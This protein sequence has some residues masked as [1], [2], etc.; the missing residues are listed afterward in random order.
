VSR[1]GRR[2]RAKGSCSSCRS[3]FSRAKRLGE[4]ILALA[5]GPSQRRATSVEAAFP[6]PAVV[7]MR[8]VTLPTP[9]RGVNGMG[10]LSVHVFL[11]WATAP[12][13]RASP[14][15]TATASRP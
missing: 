8:R 10:S 14:H 3:C 9:G 4:E 7:R 12:T 6:A 13:R 11:L 2:Q 5:F 1:G 15:D